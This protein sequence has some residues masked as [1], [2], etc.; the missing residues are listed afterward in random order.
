MNDTEKTRRYY[1]SF[2]GAHRTKI[3]EAVDEPAI[4]DEVLKLPARVEKDAATTLIEK[5]EFTNSE[6]FTELELYQLKMLL[7][8]QNVTAEDINNF[9]SSSNIEVIDINTKFIPNAK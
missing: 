8:G 7:E 3:E 1:E 5:V 9:I 6:I 4:E 2:E